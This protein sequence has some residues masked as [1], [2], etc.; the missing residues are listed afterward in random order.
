MSALNAVVKEHIE[1]Y[2]KRVEL[3]RPDHVE[4]IIDGKTRLVPSLDVLLN[5]TVFQDTTSINQDLIKKE[6][7]KLHEADQ[8]LILAAMKRD[9]EK[10]IQTIQNPKV[11]L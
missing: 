6:F 3:V 4:V 5:A 10:N 8:S 11:K 9:I 1:A 2:F 7:E